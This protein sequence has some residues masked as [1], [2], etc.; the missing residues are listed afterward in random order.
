[1]WIYNQH[2]LKAPFEA[3]AWV[4]PAGIGKGMSAPGRARLG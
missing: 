2:N 4:P 3:T 1:M